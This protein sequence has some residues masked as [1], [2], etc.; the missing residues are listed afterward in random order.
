[1]PRKIAACL[2]NFAS[3]GK[4]SLIRIPET[5]VSIDLNSPRICSGASGFKSKVSK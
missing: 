5:E 3:F 2:I 4:C 1:M